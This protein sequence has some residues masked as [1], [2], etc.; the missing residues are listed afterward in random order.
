METSLMRFEVFS[1]FC[2][3]SS[4][5]SLVSF[6]IEEPFLAWIIASSIMVAVSVAASAERW[7]RDFTSSA[8]TAKPRP[9]SPALAAS[10]AALRARSFV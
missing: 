1:I 9:C 5:A 7:A 8:T 2:K 3:I 6:E 4:N 10:T